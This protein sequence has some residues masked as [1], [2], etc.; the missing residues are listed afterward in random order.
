MKAGL[1]IVGK[2]L[3]DVIVETVDEGSDERT[4]AGI[5]VFS[6]L[7]PRKA[8]NMAAVGGSEDIEFAVLAGTFADIRPL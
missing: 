3:F 7:Y 5:R 4:L 1:I 2:K 8:E 6:G